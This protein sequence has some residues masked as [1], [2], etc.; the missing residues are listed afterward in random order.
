MSSPELCICEMVFRVYL[1]SMFCERVLLP[2]FVSELRIHG[3]PEQKCFPHIQAIAP[4]LR[5]LIIY[6]YGFEVLP[7][8]LQLFTSLSRLEISNCPNLES[9]PDLQELHSLAELLI[10]HCDNLKSIPDLG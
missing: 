4:H 9:L 7:S 8:W 6:D 5:R 3:C 10:H 1:G 2:L